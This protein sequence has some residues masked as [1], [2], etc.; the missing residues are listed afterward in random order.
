MN[1][2]IVFVENL[3]FKD[4]RPYFTNIIGPEHS[5]IWQDLKDGKTVI[6][7]DNTCIMDILIGI[8]KNKCIVKEVPE[9]VEDIC[10][11]YCAIPIST[12]EVMKL[13]AN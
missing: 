8:E 11:G 2:A 13:L 9:V 7:K 10:I 12:R 4:V 6:E 1:S 5:R 3:K